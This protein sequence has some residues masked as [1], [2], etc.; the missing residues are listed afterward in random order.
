MSMPVKMRRALPGAWGREGAARRAEGSHATTGVGRMRWR[1][2]KIER[3]WSGG[4]GGGSAEGIKVEGS[5]NQESKGAD[6]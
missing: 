6:G 2:I 5:A 4:T 1:E 3:G